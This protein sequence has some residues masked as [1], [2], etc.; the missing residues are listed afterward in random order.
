MALLTM[1]IIEIHQLEGFDPQGRSFNRNVEVYRSEK[2]FSARFQ[3][4]GIS[5]ESAT[6]VT[7]AEAMADL[8]RTIQHK[9]F[10]KLRTRVN[11]KGKRY[12]AERQPWVDYPD[13][14][15]TKDR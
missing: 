13:S 14:L 4:E 15:E 8:V 10:R 9:G 2:G 1:M 12:F 11:F 7:I 3:Y 6:F 5:A